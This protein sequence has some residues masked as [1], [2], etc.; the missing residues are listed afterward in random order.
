MLLLLIYGSIVGTIF[1]SLINTF[2]LLHQIRS[3]NVSFINKILAFCMDLFHN[4]LIGSAVPIISILL[5]LIFVKRTYN[6]PLLL[7]LVL[8]YIIVIV[9]FFRYEM[10]ILTIIYNE[11]LDIHPCTPYSFIQERIRYDLYVNQYLSEENQN[12]VMNAKSFMLYW[13]YAFIIIIA[14]II[15]YLLHYMQCTNR[16]IEALIIISSLTIYFSRPDY[17]HKKS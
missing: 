2:L 4:I 8:L 9:C 12:C 1:L 13:K 6:V 14:L 11:L 15:I 17:V 5:Y 10:C 7:V 16:L 3:A